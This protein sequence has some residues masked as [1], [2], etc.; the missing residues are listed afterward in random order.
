MSRVLQLVWDLMTQLGSFVTIHALI[1][2]K[3]LLFSRIENWKRIVATVCESYQS[4]N[5]TWRTVDGL[6]WTSFFILLL[7]GSNTYLVLRIFL[8]FNYMRNQISLQPVVGVLF[9]F[10][11]ATVKIIKEVNY[12]TEFLEFLVFLVGSIPTIDFFSKDKFPSSYSLEE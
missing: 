3:D 10:S 5:Q 6:L 12:G 2:L 11:L 9:I 8:L 1:V 7:K 4:S